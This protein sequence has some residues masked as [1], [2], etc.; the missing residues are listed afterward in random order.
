M[1]TASG[2]SALLQAALSLFAER[3]FEGTS[4]RAIAERA[5]VPQGLIRHHFG[6][7]DGLFHEVVDAGLR[8]LA[9]AA[10]D[11]VGSEPPS[12]A[13]GLTAALRSAPWL[14]VVVHALL[15]PGPRRAWLVEQRLRP[16]LQRLGPALAEFLKRPTPLREQDALALV[17]ALSAPLLLAPLMAP[18]PLTEATESSLRAHLL[19]QSLAA[20]HPP[21]ATTRG[22]G[23]WGALGSRTTRR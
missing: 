22:A 8:A 19:G 3:G 7:K 12:P 15:E 17:G 10:G 9:P 18:G 5:G 21:P 6:S 13:A 11:A 14:C 1:P 23:P 4:T 20:L 2:R 16:L